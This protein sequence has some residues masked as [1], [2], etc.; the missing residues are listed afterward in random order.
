M[1]SRRKR[2]AA[3]TTRSGF[4]LIELL[5]VIAIISI[6]VSLLLPAVQMARE[7]ARRSQCINNLKQIGIAIHN[8]HDSRGY[9]PSVARCGAGPEDLNPGM[10]NIWYEYRHTPPSIYLL[11]Y[12]DQG[13]I[14]SQWN[15]NASG[16]DNVT[17]A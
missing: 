10:Q 9:L 16:S 1:K 11:P 17:P 13:N 8:F 15:L 6:L 12:L 2:S 14:Y 7:S 5:V 3:R 4:T